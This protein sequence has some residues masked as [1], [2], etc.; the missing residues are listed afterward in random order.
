[1]A[2]A[3]ERGEPVSLIMLDLD[4]FKHINDTHGHQAGDLVLREVGG[5][6]G[7]VVRG[8]DRVGRL[9]GEEFGIL[10][11]GLEAEEAVQVALRLRR[12]V[13]ALRPGGHAVTASLGVASGT[14]GVDAILARAD[15]CLY[16]AKGA[17]RNRVSFRD[18]ATCRATLVENGTS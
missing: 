17:G 1:M 14:D 16:A 11:P 15:E 8:Q 6:L 12:A 10:L 7:R 9:G 13:A 5:C 2:R 3:T 4:H 18:T